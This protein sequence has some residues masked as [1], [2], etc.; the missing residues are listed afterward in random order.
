MENSHTGNKLCAFLTVWLFCSNLS[1]Q[2]PKH[3]GVEAAPGQRS[4]W[5][6]HP[7]YFGADYYPEDYSLEQVQQDAA[8][9]QRAGFNVVRLLDSNWAKIEVTDGQFS[10]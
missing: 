8:S 7:F 2:Q 5:T 1:S 10:F 3:L 6:S 4:V 9:M